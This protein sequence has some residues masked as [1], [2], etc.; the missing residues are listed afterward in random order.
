MSV[1]QQ[2]FFLLELPQKQIPR[3][4]NSLHIS[5]MGRRVFVGRGF[6]PL[7]VWC[8]KARSCILRLWKLYGNCMETVWKLYGNCMETAWKLHGNCMETVNETV[9]KLLWNSETSSGQSVL[10]TSR[11]GQELGIQR[12]L[13]GPLC[14]FHNLSLGRSE[15]SRNEVRIC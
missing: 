10:D 8:N 13:A 9:W 14:R 11:F 7:N 6:S 1:F 5:S 15:M 2:I 3:N 12:E 4:E